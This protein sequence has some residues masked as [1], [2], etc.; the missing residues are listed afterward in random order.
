MQR[1]VREKKITVSYFTEKE[2]DYRSIIL[3][4]SY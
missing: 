3:H 2:K 1:N 4:C